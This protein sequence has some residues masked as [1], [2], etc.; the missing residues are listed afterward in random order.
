MGVVRKLADQNRTCVATIH[1]PSPEVFA[2]F[3]KVLL[4]SAGRLI[5]FG[6]SADVIPYL[7]QPALGYKYNGTQNPAEF[8]IDVSNGQ[9]FPNDFK[10]SRLPDELET[11]YTRTKYYVPPAKTGGFGTK[12]TADANSP[13]TSK[14]A[15]TLFTH[16]LM[17]MERTWIATIRDTRDMSTQLL[18]NVGGVFT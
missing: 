16:F 18:K 15:T 12:A 17:L 7:T 5:Y 4:V 13:Y 14:Y 1:Q 8:M 3:D 9:I 2:L 6:S 11:I 10:I